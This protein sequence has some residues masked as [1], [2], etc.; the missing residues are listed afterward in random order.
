[1]AVGL[2]WAASCQ[3]SRLLCLVCFPADRIKAWVI[4]EAD[5]TVAQGLPDSQSMPPRASGTLYPY[6]SI[7]WSSVMVLWQSSQIQLNDKQP[8]SKQNIWTLSLIDMIGYL[9]QRF[10]LGAFLQRI[11]L[12]PTA[13]RWDFNLLVS[14]AV[15]PLHCP[16]RVSQMAK[17][18]SRLLS[19]LYYCIS[20]LTHCWKMAMQF[21]SP[22]SFKNGQNH[23]RRLGLIVRDPCFIFGCLEFLKNVRNVVWWENNRFIVK[24]LGQN[25]SEIIWNWRNNFCIFYICF[26]YTA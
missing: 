25:D 23:S 9:P 4:W 6:H 7:M 22:R 3:P 8:K 2:R 12:L 17:F 14:P 21:R 18:K 5:P 19:I 26:L 10:G 15:E 11:R 16:H 24:M 1:M 13:P 20:Y